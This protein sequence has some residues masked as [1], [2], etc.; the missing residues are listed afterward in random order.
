MF[1]CTI[2]IPPNQKFKL[3]VSFV[4]FVFWFQN[5]VFSKVCP[6]QS[7]IVY[8]I[9]LGYH[10]SSATQNWVSDKTSEQ[11]S[12]PSYFPNYPCC[13]IIRDLYFVAYEIIPKNNWIVLSSPPP[14]KKTKQPTRGPPYLSN[15]NSS[16]QQK[17]CSRKVAARSS[18]HS[19]VSDWRHLIGVGEAKKHLGQK[20]AL[21]TFDSGPLLVF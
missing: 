11:W 14:A 8:W 20:S 19:L 3:F 1:G 18:T 6:R 16:P 13:W 2:L 21:R 9:L 12:K 17:L 4:L 15:K 7:K 5:K 10:D